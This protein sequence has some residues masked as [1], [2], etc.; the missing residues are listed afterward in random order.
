MSEQLKRRPRKRPGLQRPPDFCTC[1]QLQILPQQCQLAFAQAPVSAGWSWPQ[2]LPALLALP[3]WHS[4]HFMHAC[5]HVMHSSPH[6]RNFFKNDFCASV[7]VAD[8]ACQGRGASSVLSA[9]QVVVQHKRNNQ[10]EIGQSMEKAI[11]DVHAWQL[12]RVILIC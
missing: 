5:I 3:A 4:K 11:C 1:P 2:L 10:S 7:C 8:D 12:L 9:A 6:S